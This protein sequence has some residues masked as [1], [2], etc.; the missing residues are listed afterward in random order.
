MRAVTYFYLLCCLA[1][2]AE[3]LKV[4]ESNLDHDGLIE[5]CLISVQISKSSSPKTTLVNE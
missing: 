1:V 2:S 5:S 4:T 3:L